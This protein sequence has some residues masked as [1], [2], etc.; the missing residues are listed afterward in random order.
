M[1]DEVIRKSQPEW[2]VKSVEPQ[3]GYVLLVT[4]VNGERKTYDCSPLLD[5]GVFKQLKDPEVFKMAHVDIDTVA[6]NDNLDIA[7]EELYQN[8]V[9]IDRH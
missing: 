8:G 3:D 5:E 1:N 6:W 7:L 2:I 4:F 9:T